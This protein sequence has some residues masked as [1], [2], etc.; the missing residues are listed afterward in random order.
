MEE[1]LK[2]L[3]QDL[4]NQIVE[5][6]G[7][8]KV[9]LHNDGEKFIL[10]DG[11]L[12]PKHRFDEVSASLAGLKEQIDQRDKELKE[13]KTL[14]GSN[15]ELA[16]KISDLEKQN[17]KQK[18]DFEKSEVTLKKQTAIKELLFNAGVL[19]ADSRELLLAKFKL[20]E[21]EILED[22]KIKDSDKLINPLKE[23]KSLGLLFGQTKVVGT[24]SNKD[25]FVPGQNGLFTQEQINKMPQTFVNANLDLIT[26][27][28][29][30][31]S[32]DNK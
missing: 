20:D 1:L 28:L 14:A 6:L 19:D 17:K 27:S 4:Y 24:D 11:K 26:K 15:T 16:Q 13:L 7:T 22:G 9:L 12:I 18:E 3:G 32:L 31:L 23:N 10:D 2:L 5:K 25:S 29:S 8:K 30:Q 21:I